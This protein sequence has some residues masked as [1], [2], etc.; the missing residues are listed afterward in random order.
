MEIRWNLPG[1]VY[2]MG[3]GPDSAKL[4]SARAAEVLQ[5]ADVVFHDPAVAGALLKMAPSRTAVYDVGKGTLEETMQRMVS[6]ARSGQTVARLICAP[7]EDEIRALREARIAFEILA[8]T[9]A[10]AE[11]VIELFRAESPGVKTV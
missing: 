3:T 4:P 8:D 1:K 11:E 9:A 6:A 10:G 7:A 5:R 2:V